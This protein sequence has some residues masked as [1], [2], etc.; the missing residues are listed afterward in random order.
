MIHMMLFVI[1]C[2]ADPSFSAYIFDEQREEQELSNEEI[3]EAVNIGLEYIHN[4]HSSQLYEL[5]LSQVEHGNF[6]CP[7]FFPAVQETQA[8]NNDCQTSEGWEFQGRSQ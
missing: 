6:Q 1:A 8:W 2:Q 7:G 4:F 5:Y 3:E